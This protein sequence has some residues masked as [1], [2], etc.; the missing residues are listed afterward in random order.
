MHK[1]AIGLCSFLLLGVAPGPMAAQEMP[2]TQATLEQFCDYGLVFD[3][4][5]EVR[6]AAPGAADQI[7]IPRRIG[8]AN[9]DEKQVAESAS[10]DP[11]PQ[12]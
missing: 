4:L 3:D 2:T 6:T 11:S 5:C 10:A 7:T 8:A 9:P 12:R 1:I